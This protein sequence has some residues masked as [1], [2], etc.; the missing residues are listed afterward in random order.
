MQTIQRK[1]QQFD[2]DGKTPGRLASEITKILIGKDKPTYM[3]N[4][5]AGDFVRVENAGK[6][7]ITGKKMNQKNYY[8]HSGFPGGLKTLSLKR[9]WE[10]DP[11]DV[12]RRAVSRML[13]KNKL[14]DERM[15]R[16]NVTN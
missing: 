8:S 9:L 1:T 13:P 10:R 12:L 15:K 11:S 4:V 7:R 16:L 5:D 14:R 3:P 2:A 6:M